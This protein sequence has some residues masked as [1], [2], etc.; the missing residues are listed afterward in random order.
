[1]RKL[2]LTELGRLSPEEFER[3]EKTPVVVVLDNIRSAMNVGSFFRTA[4]AL[5]ISKIYLCG[6]TAQPPH[7][8]ITKTAIG[9]TETVAWQHIEDIGALL[10]ELKDQGYRIVGV[11]QTTESVPL[12]TFKVQGNTALLFGNEVDGLSNSILPALDA[13]VEIPQFGTKHSLNVSVCGGI[14][15][16]HVVNSIKGNP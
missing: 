3:Q 4:D 6:I 2:K 7:K 1:M 5:A 14:V 10:L 15:L 11:E 9:A 12:N 8:E 13:C 16:W